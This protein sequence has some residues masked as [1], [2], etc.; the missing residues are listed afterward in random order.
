MPETPGR[1][2]GIIFDL[3]GTLYVSAVF[4][5]TIQDAAAGYIARLKGVSPA[6]ARQLMAAAR[7]S[8]TEETG[9]V[10]TL[11]AVCTALGGTV[12]DLHLYFEGQLRPEDHLLRDKRVIALLE[13]LAQHLPLYLFT[14]NN[15][16]LTTRIINLLG[17]NG[18]FRQIYAI[19]DRW[20]AKPDEGL[21][22]LILAEAG[23]KPA[24]ALF[25]GDRYDVD[26]RLAEQR[27]CPV[28]LSQSV[29]QLLRLEEIIGKGWPDSHTGSACP[30]A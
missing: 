20:I 3:D 15:R 9:A 22:D 28:Y 21:L 6:D 10:P 8:L 7:G 18:L 13:D 17:L 25:V 29:E 23:L 2:R 16:N 4:A 24:Q 26:L 5:A 27:G 14:N 1:I 11:S 30:P 19:D 12:P